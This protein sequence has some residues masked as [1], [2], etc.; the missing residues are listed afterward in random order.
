MVHLQVKTLS[1]S[2][3]S[4]QSIGK[5]WAV[6]SRDYFDKLPTF[7]IQS[8]KRPWQTGKQV[9]KTS[10]VHAGMGNGLVTVLARAYDLRGD[11]S[12]VHFTRASVRSIRVVR[13]TR[14]PSGT[15]KYSV[16]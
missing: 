8:T 9:W 15:P 11:M 7:G 5:S 4:I 14:V 2:G 6:L 10:N 12:A 13:K 1:K 16:P 3:P